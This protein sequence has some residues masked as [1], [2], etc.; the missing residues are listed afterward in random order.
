MTTIFGGMDLI[1]GAVIPYEMEQLG[2]KY[3]LAPV[4]GRD[5]F[6]VYEAD[7]IRIGDRTFGIRK[8][9]RIRQAGVQVLV[10]SNATSEDLGVLLDDLGI[11]ADDC[12][13]VHPNL[14]PSQSDNGQNPSP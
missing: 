14:R 3:Y 4:S 10:S 5:E 8:Y 2:K 6:D 9:L 13:R 1:V 12:Y 11:T 7:I